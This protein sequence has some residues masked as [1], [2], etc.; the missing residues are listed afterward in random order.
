MSQTA[1]PHLWQMFGAYFHQDWDT[2]G[3][4]WPDLVCNFADGKSQSELDAT[5]TEVDQLVADFPNDATLDLELFNVLGCSY[6]LRPDLGGPTVRVWLGQIAA[7]LRAGARHA[8]Q[9]PCT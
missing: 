6:L 5:A 2:E 1:Y 7:F 4:D 9:G 8:E 3:H